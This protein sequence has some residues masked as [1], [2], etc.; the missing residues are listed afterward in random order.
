[1]GQLR[2]RIIH[3]FSIYCK[4]IKSEIIFLTKNEKKYF[5]YLKPLPNPGCL[6]SANAR[7]A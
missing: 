1:M 7:G 4:N 6:L 3:S 5:Y 2:T